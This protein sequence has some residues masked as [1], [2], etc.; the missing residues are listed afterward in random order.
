MQPDG[1]IVPWILNFLQMSPS[2]QLRLGSELLPGSWVMGE[3]L[4]DPLK[5][6]LISPE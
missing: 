3:M 6:D 2:P 1:R 4:G 5:E